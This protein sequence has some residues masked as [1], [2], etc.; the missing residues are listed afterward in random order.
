M[1]IPFTFE[2]YVNIPKFDLQ[3]YMGS[4]KTIYDMSGTYF[5]GN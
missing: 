2:V 4:L 3:T 1:N 5:D